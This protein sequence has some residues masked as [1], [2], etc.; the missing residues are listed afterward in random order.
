[1]T[2]K[3]KTI[4][5]KPI[6]DKVNRMLYL[7]DDTI[8]PPVNEHSRR[9]WAGLLEWILFDTG[10]YNGFG[11]QDSE[12]N[13]TDDGRRLKN[14]TDRDDSRRYY[15]GGHMSRQ[16]WESFKALREEQQSKFVGPSR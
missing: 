6:I 3:R 5:V 1:M 12:F 10:N 7:P 16:H 14:D 9:A 15:Y 2:R 8:N 4:E 11:Y 13:P